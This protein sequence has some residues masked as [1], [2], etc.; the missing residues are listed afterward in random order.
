M[1]VISAVPCL[2]ANTRQHHNRPLLQ[3]QHK[4]DI[5][6]D[7]AH[8]HTNYFL[9]TPF[10]EFLTLMIMYA[11]EE[12]SI[13]SKIAEIGT[14][15]LLFILLVP[16]TALGYFAE[17]SLPN[18]PLYPVKRGIEQVVLTLV[19]VN[20]SAKS[21]YELSLANTRFTETKKLLASDTPI[22]QQSL[23]QLDTVTQQLTAAQASIN[24]VSDP[25][26]KAK[27]Q[28]QFQSSIQSYQTQ[29]S[30]IQQ[31]LQTVQVSNT[32]TQPQTHQQ[33]SSEPT[34]ATPSPKTQEPTPTDNTVSQQTA[35]QN[36][37][38]ADTSV[39]QIDTQ[40]MTPE[41]QAALEQTL[42]QLQAQLQNFQNNTMHGDQQEKPTRSN[43]G[44]ERQDN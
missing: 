40:N 19:S 13:W 7:I 21:A 9:L 35:P 23:Q 22:N 1:Q 5:S 4:H 34:Q 12:E 17:N 42:N 24:T 32:T 30:Q 10:S 38:T 37:S 27:L 6:A 39:P 18:S 41:Q 26:Q 16:G 29:I 3:R 8:R 15:V 2:Q 20:T 36:T 11:F 44:T 31:Q 28:V 33:S 14:W 43:K 25:I